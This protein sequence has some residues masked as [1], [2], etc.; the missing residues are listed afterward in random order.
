MRLIYTTFL[1]YCILPNTYATTIQPGSLVIS[2]VMANP[3]QVS[4]AN[5]EWIEIFN[6]TANTID[7]NGITLSDD[8]SNTHQINN[9]GTLLIASGAYFVLGRNGDSTVNGGYIA[10]YVYDN[11]T[12][13]N[14]TDQIILTMDSVEITRLDYSGSPFGIAG[15]SAELITQTSNPTNLDYQLTQSNRYGLGDIGTPGNPGAFQLTAASPVPIPNALW[16][17][18]SAILLLIRKAKI[19][20]QTNL[21]PSSPN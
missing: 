8:G 13:S 1:L 12:L 20:R 16:L 7:I 18:A 9:N 2:E 5:G 19:S 3:S 4:D 10:D 14:S 21:Q 11:F 15:I 6:A 17:F